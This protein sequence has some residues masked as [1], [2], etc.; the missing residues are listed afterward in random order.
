MPD[1]PLNDLDLVEGVL[2]AAS[3]AAGWFSGMAYH[4]RTPLGRKPNGLH[5]R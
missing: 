2:L 3:F 4:G 1:L 5:G